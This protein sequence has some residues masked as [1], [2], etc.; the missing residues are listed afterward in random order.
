MSMKK[1]KNIT[2][3]VIVLS[4]ACATMCS[5]Q[6][7]DSSGWKCLLSFCKNQDTVEFPFRTFQAEFIFETFKINYWKLRVSYTERDLVDVQMSLKR[8]VRVFQTVPV[9]NTPHRVRIPT[10]TVAE[11]D[12]NC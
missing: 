5:A 11:R 7:S 10:C 8:H 2:T 6:T 1:R 4:S 9:L 12:T 3:F